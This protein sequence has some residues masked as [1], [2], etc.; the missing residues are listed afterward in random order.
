MNSWKH[1]VQTI[2]ERKAVSTLAV[3]FTLTVGIL[4]GTLVSRGV[5]AARQQSQV[6]DAQQVELPSPVQLSSIFNTISKEIAPSV[7][8]INTESTV[9][10]RSQSR[11][12]PRGQQDPFGDF[13]RRFFDFGP[14]G[15]PGREFRQKSLGSGVII[16][17]KGYILTNDHVVSKADKIK[18]KMM[19]D[20]KLYDAKVIGSDSETDIAVIK[21]EADHP[22]PYASVGNSE[23]L[24]VGDWVLAVGSPFGLEETVTAGIISAKGRD[25]GSQFQRFIQTDAAINPGN[26]G[27][28]LVNMAGEVIGINTAIATGTG[29][30]AGVGFALP[31]N[32]A[33]SVYNQIVKSGRVT[34]GSIGVTFQPE[35]SP[36]LLRSFGASNGVVITGIQPDGPADH[37]G[38]K[39]GDVILSIDGDTVQDGDELVAKVASTPVGQS[40]TIRYVRNQ[41]E[42][43]TEL[44]IGDR[45][46]V[47]ASILGTEE[48]YRPSEQE[49]TEAKFGVSIQNV[50]PEIASQ[51]GIDETRGV[52]VTAVDTDSFADEVGLQ[53]GDVILEI[54]QQRVDGVNDVVRIQRDLH[55]G[56]DVVFLIQRNRRGQ[57]L[58]LYLADTLP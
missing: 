37:A 1:F 36:V 26:S 6:S 48:G 16:D 10:S 23:G 3:L 2:K 11:R 31:S 55:S 18:V 44:V 4:I 34:R 21:I 49:D 13:F 33:F 22:L 41:Q 32:T 53:R 15:E 17:P 50:T 38:L 30:Y 14:Q 35:Q 8:N 43:E 19:D 7:V 27:G 42:Q 57:T 47:F 40:V 58:T 56:S 5:R 51:L 39:Q 24:S 28:P 45:S 52:V 12:N 29:S 46:K 54:N 20:E 25:L 9:Q